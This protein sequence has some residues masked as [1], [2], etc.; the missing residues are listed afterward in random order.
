SEGV[1]ELAE[2]LEA[3]R[4]AAVAT[5]AGPERRLLP[6]AAGKEA[7]QQVA[8]K[9]RREEAVLG[10]VQGDGSAVGLVPQ[11]GVAVGVEQLDLLAGL[12]QRV[13]P[14]PVGP[15]AQ[16]AGPRPGA[17]SSAAEDVLEGTPHQRMRVDH[18]R[19]ARGAADALQQ[20][21]PDQFLDLCREPV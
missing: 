12:F 1:R 8:L 19:L 10:V 6:V 11:A 15:A 9:G 20:T 16:E 21:E 7:Q 2:Q 13:R 17:V 18:R 5:E 3:D 14:A 4:E